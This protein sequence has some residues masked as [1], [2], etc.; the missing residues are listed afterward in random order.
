LIK[1]FHE[2]LAPGGLLLV[3]NVTPQTPNR[4]SL[5]LILDWHLIYRNTAQFAQLCSGIIPEE[6]VRMRTDDTGVNIFMEA[7]KSDDH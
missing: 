4:G 3:T 5:D 7:R 2:W 6:M 1:I